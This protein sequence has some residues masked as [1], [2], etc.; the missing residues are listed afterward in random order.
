MPVSSPGMTA[1]RGAYTC[2]HHISG[3]QTYVLISAPRL[4]GCSAPFVS[5]PGLSPG[6]SAP[7]EG[8]ERRK[9][10]NKLAPCEGARV[11]CDRHARLPALHVWRLSARDRCSGL[12][13]TSLTSPR[14]RRHWR[15]PS[16]RPRPALKGRRPSRDGSGRW[17][18]TTRDPVCVSTGTRAP[19]P[20][21]PA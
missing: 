2:A 18:E 12:G 6:G 4:R 5:C 8:A 15:R 14:S 7:S 11:P 16:V 21:P 20:A 17:S 13:Q 9:A 19:H 3:F 1:E 10:R